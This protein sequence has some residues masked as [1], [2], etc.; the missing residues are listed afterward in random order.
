MSLI[1]RLFV[2]SL[3]I[4]T[5]LWSFG[6][7]TVKAEGSYG[8]GSLLAKEGVEGTAVYYI[9]SDDQ[10]YIFPDGK[11]YSTWYADFN[12]VVRVSVDELDMYDNGGTVTYR[13]GT[14]L[15]THSDTNKIYAIGTGGV[16]HWIPTAEVAEALYGANWGSMV[17]D[18]IPGFFSSYADG[19]D[20]SDT[21]PNGTLLQLGEDMYYVVDGD[22]RTFADSDAFDANNFDYDNLI[23]VADVD[24]YGT[25]ESVTGEETGLSGFMPAEDDG[26]DVVFDGEVSIALAS[27]TPA[28]GLV[29]AGAARV[30]FT[31]VKFSNG[32]SS[33]VTVDSLVVER[34]G[35]GQDAAFA[36]LDLLDGGTMLP[37]NRSS[38]SLSSLHTASFNDDFVVEAN[39][40]MYVYIAAN[41]ASSLA[42]YAGEFPV[43]AVKSVV[44]A[45]GSL[46]GSLPIAGN[47]QTLNGTLTIGSATV[48]AGGN[49]PSAST[50]EVGTTDFII[51]SVRVTAG[52]AEDLTLDRLIFTNNGSSDPEDLTNV[53]LVNTN[54]GEVVETMESLSSDA[55]DFNDLAV[56]IEKGKNV[57]FDLRADIVNGSGSSISYDIDKQADITVTGDTYGYMILPTYPNS[58][59]PYFDANDT[60]IGNGS[61]RVESVAV[62]PTN[63]T[64]GLSDVTLGKFNFVAKGEA[65]NITSIGWNFDFV[66][67]GTTYTSD[68]T[69]V[70]V[71]DEDGNAVAGPM[72]PTYATGSNATTDSATATTTDTITVP[73]GE[74]TYTVKGDLSSDWTANDTIKAGIF[75][76]TI[77]MKGDITGNTITATPA[78]ATQSTTLTVKSA[79]STVTVST[80]PAAQTVVSGAQDFVVAKYVFD[81]GTSGDAVEITAI[82]PTLKTTNS[83][84]A[85]LSGWTLWEGD[86][87]IDINAESTTCSSSNVCTTL[88]GSSTTTL[89]L[90]DNALVIPAGETKVVTVKADVGTSTSTGSFAVGLQGGG[91][92]AVDSDAQTVTP[93]ITGADGQSMTLATGGTLNVAVST[94]PASAAVVANSTVEV[95]RVTLQAKYEGM[96]FNYL[97]FTIQDPDGGIIGNQDEVTSLGLYTEAGVQVGNSVSVNAANATITPTGMSLAVNEES[98]YVIKATFAGLSDASPASSAAGVRVLLS[99]VDVD[100]TAV[101]SS[102]ITKSGLGTAFNTFSVYK[103]LPTVAQVDFTGSDNISGSGTYNLKK[104]SVTADSTGPIGLYKFTFGVSTSSESLTD[105]GY[106]LYESD[107]SSSLGNVIAKG[108]D[109]TVTHETGQVAI[110]E[111]YLDVNDDTTAA[112]ALEHRVIALGATKYYTLRGYVTEDGTANNGSISTVFAGDPVFAG[113]APLKAEVTDSTAQNDFIWSDLNFD[114]YSTSTATQTMGWFNGFRVPGL[115]TTSST[116]QIIT[117]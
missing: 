52:S 12:D 82:K 109:I 73:V 34:M 88:S 57:T 47:A 40:T 91:V 58:S 27:D 43:L 108:S 107:S 66:T 54:T 85:V 46:S 86:T 15:V 101:G 50:K 56:A 87:E 75:A 89:T 105:S 3:V 62:A 48:A 90:T 16:A 67:T 117:D 11:T 64:E 21:Y 113:T 45:E 61:I 81:G 6:G 32:S 55:L 10:K 17:M 53:E 116:G 76:G 24:A 102:S 41:M 8:A 72:D 25:G 80:D 30:P 68:I 59:E 22:V 65:M 115:D 29:V 37:L 23:E 7:L 104:F 98:T 110:L 78:G 99:N 92:T 1:K 44:L 100:G 5:V 114:L 77:V 74:T 79:A 36:S 9:G 20:L 31:K 84:P 112:P 14:K 38:K 51:G 35:L 96:N 95:G 94:D 63:V 93:T 49:N 33:D 111:V 71:Y 13:A 18:V 4:T 97:G 60:T 103:S 28:S 69:N 2:F 70:T 42:D 83:H 106:Y 19:A 26:D 39:S